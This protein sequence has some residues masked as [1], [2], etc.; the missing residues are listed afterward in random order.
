MATILSYS[1][2]GI[3]DK[4]LFNFD[5]M[6]STDFKLS[7]PIAVSVSEPFVY[8]QYLSGQGSNATWTPDVSAVYWNQTQIANINLILN[9][10]K[11]FINVSFSTV[12]DY[13]NY[14]PLGVGIFTSS[15][16]NIS[17][18]YRTDLPWSGQSSLNLNSYAYVGSELD[19]VLNDA[20]FGTSDYSLSTT[21]FGGHALMH[22]L[23]HSLGLSHPF[24]P[25][26]TAVTA[27]YSATTTVGFNKLGFVINGAG[28]MN[29]EYFSIMSYDNEK[30]LNSVDTYAQT[31]MI[32][33]V[34]ALQDAYGAGGGSSGTGN[35][36]IT[37]GS[38]SGLNSYRTYFDTG[39]IDTINL[40]NYA[41]GVYLHM[42][43]SIVG[44]SHLV[45]VSMSISDYQ[46]MVSSGSPQSL[47]WFYGEFENA[48]GSTGT[49]LII[50]NDLN[51]VITATSGNDTIDGGGGI[52]T[53]IFGAKSSDFTRNLG[54]QT[55]VVDN[56][57]NRYS[58]E[59]FTNIERLQ[60]TDTNIALDIA[61]TQTAGEAYLLYQAA[62]NRHPDTP[63]V[64]YWIATLDAGMNIVTVTQAFINSPEFIGLY[65]ANPSVSNYVNLLYQNVL[66]RA[67]EAGGVNYWNGQLNN[68]IFS[69]AQVLEYFAASPENVAAVAP[70]IAHGIAYQQWVV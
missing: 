51:N 46:L 14:S 22:E 53:V 67:G 17:L 66:H 68:N 10:Y 11:Q 29:K 32:L 8:F 33:D 25:I 39:G 35:D 30:P 20:K 13:T 54:T 56:T 42:G 19:V 26:A 37:P 9:I 24:Y 50:G 34:I 28:D 2:Q 36:V 15:D 61:S 64:G 31:P 6:G 27:D 23:G 16:I 12:A 62:F 65:G 47:R 69:R 48:I 52:D 7:G 55:I 4:A 63:G 45:G 18:I 49:D 38:S 41:T 70:D 3:I 40:V 57:L 60:F 58:R 59:V 43:T 5:A 1:P 21:S 44:A